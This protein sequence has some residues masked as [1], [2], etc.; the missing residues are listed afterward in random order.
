MK[1]PRGTTCCSCWLLACSLVCSVL[2]QPAR[3]IVGVTGDHGGGAPLSFPLDSQEDLERGVGAFAPTLLELGKMANVLGDRDEGVPAEE[4]GS[5]DHSLEGQSWQSLAGTDILKG[6]CGLD[7][8]ADDGKCSIATN[9][10]RLASP[11]LLHSLKKAARTQ[12]PSFEPY[13]NNGGTIV[14]IAGADYAIIAADA[15]LVEGGVIL[16]SGV[17]RL[18]AIGEQGNVF[19]AIAGCLADAQGLLKLLHFIVCDYVWTH[20]QALRVHALSH[21]LSN[22]LYLRRR[23]PFYSFCVLAGLDDQGAGAVYGYDAIGSFERTKVACAGE[24]LKLL[25]PILD[26]LESNDGRS[27]QAKGMGGTPQ[28]NVDCD[29]ALELLKHSFQAGAEREVTMGGEVEFVIIKKDSIQRH[30]M[31][32]RSTVP[33]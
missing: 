2:V 23:F 28:V 17:S 15:W 12:A 27:P 33:R 32:T 1:R 25:Q 13:R 30:R 22:R 19:I 3:C 24:G 31:P 4:E 5:L 10:M 9:S 20:R 6:E 16:S 18:H 11:R 14:A 26:R 29:Q 21:L 8:S 7:A